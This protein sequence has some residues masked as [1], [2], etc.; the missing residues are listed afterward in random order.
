MNGVTRDYTGRQSDLE[1]LQ[2][3]VDPSGSIEMSL[4]AASG[5]SRR[6]AGVQKAIQRY[7]SLFLTDSGSVPFPV[8]PMNTLLSELKTGRVADMGYLR[9]LFNMANSATLDTIRADDY[10]TSRFGDQEDDERIAS[11]ELSG[12]TVDYSTST[13]GLSLVFTTTA[14]S[15]YSYV[16]PVSTGR[17]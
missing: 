11:V 3:V 10:N 2:T 12:M 1:F 6:V 14:G 4:T 17:G 7:V 15:D 16:L 5:T 13:I 8:S 9:H